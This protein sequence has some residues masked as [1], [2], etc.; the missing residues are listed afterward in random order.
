[1]TDVQW[2][3]L[4]PILQDLT[5][6]IARIEQFLAA[7]GLQAPTQPGQSSDG[8]PTSF[9]TPQGTSMGQFAAYAHGV[10]MGG[11]PTFQS[12][13]IPDYIVAM[14]KTGN[15]IQAIKE[16]RDVTGLGLRDAK[17]AIDQ[18]TRGR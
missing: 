5:D 1:M 18:I 16:L 2:E 13:G 7:S 17:A 12:T 3:T 4:R 6:R 15:S 11:D 10:D 8:V 9:G 14:A